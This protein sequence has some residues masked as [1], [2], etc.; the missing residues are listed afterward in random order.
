MSTTLGQPLWK[1]NSP[2]GFPDGNDAW[3]GPSAV[4]ERLRI[5]E[6]LVRD[7]D[8]ALDP[9]EAAQSLL[10]A[11]LGPQ[12]QEAITRAETREQGLEILIMSPEFQRR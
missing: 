6:L 4:R 2:K 3:I 12:T 5:S 10:G 7:I 8:A 11:A 9:G 1:P